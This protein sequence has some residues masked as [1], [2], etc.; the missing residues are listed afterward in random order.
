M[1]DSVLNSWNPDDNYG[2]ASEMGIRA[3]HGPWHIAMKMEMPE[4]EPDAKIIEARLHTNVSYRKNEGSFWVR[5]YRLLR[6]WDEASVTWYS[7][8]AA[9]RWDRP[10]ANQIDVDRSGE[11]IK[12]RE[13]IDTENLIDGFG[14]LYLG[15]HFRGK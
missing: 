3:G 9:N 6:P 2:E 1:T 15:F 11:T 12:D 10:G 8:D 5:M 4:L 7:A 14:R 13:G